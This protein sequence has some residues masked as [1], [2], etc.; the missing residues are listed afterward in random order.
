[1]N[2]KQKQFEVM[3]KESLQKQLQLILYVI[4]VKQR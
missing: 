3:E 2:Y 4:R 1:M